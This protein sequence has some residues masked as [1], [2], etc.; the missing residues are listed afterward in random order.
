LREGEGFGGTGFEG[1]TGRKSE[2]DVEELVD[3][4]DVF[5]PVF[6]DCVTVVAFVLVV[7]FDDARL[8]SESSGSSISRPWGWRELMG[9]GD[10]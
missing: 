5:D 7:A 6:T 2:G 9:R 8:G 1:W 4:V 3:G 10:E